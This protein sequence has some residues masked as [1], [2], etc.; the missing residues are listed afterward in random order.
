[1]LRNMASKSA[2]ARSRMSL[3]RLRLISK[4]CLFSLFLSDIAYGVGGQPSEVCFSVSVPFADSQLFEP[5]YL[6]TEWPCWG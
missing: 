1:M 6:R 3:T 4:S 5:T 2:Q